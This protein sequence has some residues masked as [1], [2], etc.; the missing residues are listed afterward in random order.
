MR[1]TIG[2]S[3]NGS[4]GAAAR[5]AGCLGSRGARRRICWLTML[6][7]VDLRRKGAKTQRKASEDRLQDPSRCPV[8]RGSTVSGSDGLLPLRYL[9]LAPLH[10]SCC[11]VFFALLFFACLRLCVEGLIVNLRRAFPQQPLHEPPHLRALARCR[12]GDYPVRAIAR[13]AIRKQQLERSI[14]HQ[15]AHQRHAPQRDPLTAE[16]GTDHLLVMIEM[17]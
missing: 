10:P 14:R 12:R 7:A 1:T 8:L 4:T 2:S 3:T 5:R 6:Y 15:R 17:D 13:R 11:S 9:R 16:R